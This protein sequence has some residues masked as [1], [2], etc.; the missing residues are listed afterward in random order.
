MNKIQYL[1]SKHVPTFAALV[2]FVLMLLVILSSVFVSARWP[3]DTSGWYLGST[4]GRLVSI[5]ILLAMLARVGWLRPAGFTSLGNWGPWLLILIPL[6]YAIAAFAFVMTGNLNFRFSIPA[7]T[8]VAFLFLMTHAFMEE[9]AFR[10]L[11]LHGFEQALGSSKRDSVK[12]VSISSM[13]FGGMH[14]LYI[15]GEPL[16]IVLLRMISAFLLGILFGALVL[17]S[18]SIYP[19]T[20][21]HGVL[22]FAGY[23][24]LTS[25]AVQGTPT[26][27]LGLSLA[28]LP[29]A[30]L[31]LYLLRGLPER[32]AVAVT[33]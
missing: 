6:A 4:I 3:G 11:I 33:V 1:A 2:T 21:F 25:N 5:F 10:G 24:N 16:P 26:G 27:W 18:K 17:R 32:S 7:L 19:A 22:N 13:Y 29:L 8:G 30:L 20:I 9:T 28:M 14:I 12:S 31:G 15:L 23:L